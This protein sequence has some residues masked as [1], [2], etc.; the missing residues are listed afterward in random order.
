MSQEQKLTGRKTITQPKRSLNATD[1][2]FLV[3][4]VNPVYVSTS[5]ETIVGGPWL[6]QREIADWKNLSQFRPNVSADQATS[7]VVNA[8]GKY[9]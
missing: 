7:P 9:T 5:T 3:L 8:C 4:L 2:V 1:I 6:M